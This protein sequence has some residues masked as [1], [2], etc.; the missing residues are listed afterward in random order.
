MKPKEETTQL[1]TRNQNFRCI[2]FYI[3]YKDWDRLKFPSFLS[4]LPRKGY[5]WHTVA[6]LCHSHLVVAAARPARPA[7]VR[8]DH[9]PHTHELH[10]GLYISLFE[11]TSFRSGWKN[12]N[13]KNVDRSSSF[14][15]GDFSSQNRIVKQV[16]HHYYTGS[17][18]LRLFLCSTFLF[19]YI[20]I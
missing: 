9:A 6:L 16:N 20:S 11:R 8:D 17:P 19:F 5:N 7:W 12:N 14:T 18:R 3:I 13:L 10:F 4:R 2:Y 15:K 1:I